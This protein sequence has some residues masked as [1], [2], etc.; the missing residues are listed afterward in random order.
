MAGWSAKEHDPLRYVY[1]WPRTD[2]TRFSHCLVMR[3]ESSA[4]REKEVTA[5]ERFD[6]DDT[7][8]SENQQWII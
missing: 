5:P 7:V 2:A 1:T 8:N 4:G 3:T 6:P